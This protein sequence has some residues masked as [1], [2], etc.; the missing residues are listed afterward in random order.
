MQHKIERLRGY[1]SE[2]KMYVYTCKCGKKIEAKSYKEAV[3][4]HNNE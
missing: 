2:T 3:R 1:N 4:K